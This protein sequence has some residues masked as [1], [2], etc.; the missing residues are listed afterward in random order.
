MKS[1]KI[2]ITELLPD[3]KNPR[4]DLQPEDPEFKKI[5]NSIRSFGFLE[6]IIFNTRTKKIVGGHQRLKTVAFRGIKELHTIQ[7]GA[8]T[9]AFTD[10]ELKELSEQ[11]EMAANIALNKAQGDWDMEQLFS[12]LQELKESDFDIALTG[13]DE[14]L[15][16]E[17]LDATTPIDAP[18]F[19]P[20]DESGVPRLD[21]KKHAIC[22][23]CGCDFI[24]K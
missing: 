17:M 15:F 3:L 13:F 18:N 4:K 16:G 5:D 8:Y 11:E 20:S 19:L 10:T 24:P 9:W 14:N 6:P 2:A 21:E 1:G 22:P 7:L 12:N 23:E